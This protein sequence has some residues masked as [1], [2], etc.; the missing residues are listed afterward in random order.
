[1]DSLPLSHQGG[2]VLPFL[3]ALLLNQG[4]LGDVG[5]PPWLAQL[6]CSRRPEGGGRAA[7]P[8]VSM[9]APAHRPPAPELSE[10]SRVCRRV[11]WIPRA[12]GPC[13]VLVGCP[14]AVAHG[15]VTPS[16]K[17]FVL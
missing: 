4:T 14:G 12:E 9:R 1:M 13:W 8:A 10:L 6:G 16:K 15:K 7:A 11:F 3:K 5:G 17:T 2:P